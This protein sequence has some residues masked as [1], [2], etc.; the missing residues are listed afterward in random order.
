MSYLIISI[1]AVVIF[2]LLDT[3]RY[4][5]KQSKKYKNW[6]RDVDAK[7]ID[8]IEKYCELSTS[9]AIRTN[10]QL[11]NARAKIAQLYKDSKP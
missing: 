7:H 6:Y 11:K 4:H 2:I 1:M 8:L 9:T 10:R 3:S 5:K